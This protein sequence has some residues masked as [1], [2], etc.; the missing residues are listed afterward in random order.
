MGAPSTR[1]I[2]KASGTTQLAVQFDQAKVS[3][4]FITETL[5]IG[6]INKPAPDAPLNNCTYSRYPCSLVQRI[7]FAIN[8]QSVYA[9]LSVF[10][11]LSDLNAATLSRDGKYYVLTLEGGDAAASYEAVIRFDKDQVHSRDLIWSEANQIAEHSI[12]PVLVPLG[13]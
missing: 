1:I 11:D 2:V 5:D 8:G 12:Y 9:L 6:S 7:G 13:Q 4:T 3:V 10:G